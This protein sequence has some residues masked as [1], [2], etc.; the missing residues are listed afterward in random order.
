MSASLA[1]TIGYQSRVKPRHW[2]LRRE[3]LNEKRMRTAM[4]RNRKT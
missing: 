2:K 4:G 1:N 3:S